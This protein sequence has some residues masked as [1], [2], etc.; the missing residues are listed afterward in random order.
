MAQRKVGVFT[1]GVIALALLAT[2]APPYVRYV[3]ERIAIA[4]L[5]AVGFNLVFGLAGIA[6]LGNAA[7]Y[8]LGAYIAGIVGMQHGQPWYVVLALATTCGAILGAL[9]ALFTA[10]TRG[11]YALLLTLTL[12]QSVWGLASQNV[13]L[14]Q[15]DTGLIGITHALPLAPPDPGF[16]ALIVTLAAL[17]C[18]VA[19]LVWVST[20]GLVIAATATNE[21][22]ARALGLGILGPR[23]TSFALSGALCALAGVMSAQLRGS[24][25]PSDLDWPMSAAVLVAALIGGST[26]VFG[27]ALGAFAFVALETILGDFT[28]R[29]QMILGALMA[30]AAIVLPGGLLRARPRRYP[31]GTHVDRQLPRTAFAGPLLDIDGLRYGFG[32]R[33]LFADFSLHIA[34]GERVAIVGPNGVGKSTLFALIGGDLIAEHG[35]IRFAGRDVRR[36]GTVR[37]ARAGIG[38]TYQFG[39]LFETRTVWE[40]LA[41]AHAAQH[42]RTLVRPLAG[43]ANLLREVER[44]LQRF[45]LRAIADAR[46]DA[47]S[48]GTRRRV[49]LA[50]AFAPRPLLVLLDEPTA[51]L[52][53][54]E[55]D[56]VLRAIEALPRD[57]ALLVIEHDAD[58]AARLCTSVTRLGEPNVLRPS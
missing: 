11:I 55:I 51:G 14:T 6:S 5:F 57:V 21:R 43:D 56:A 31:A 42:P 32:G 36:A 49:E 23:M 18:A 34:A 52:E 54:G 19:W 7:F 3:I 58:V 40:N 2:F 25:S 30:T 15:G 24:V 22:R 13:A 27:P 26:T 17:G 47:L 38:R 4:G 41:V 9:F 1:A 46:V 44:S 10:R 50:V 35:R 29:W 53:R 33:T 37:R 12:A 20:S 16:G 48:H 39:S 45:D 28:G 8:G